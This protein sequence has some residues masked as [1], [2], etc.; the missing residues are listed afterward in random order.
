MKAYRTLFLRVA[1][2][3]MLLCSMPIFSRTATACPDEIS[4]P[5]SF[6]AVSGGSQ[7]QTWTAIDLIGASVLAKAHITAGSDVFS[8]DDSVILFS[9]S[10][11]TAGATATFTVTFAPGVNATGTFTGTLTCD[12][13][14]TYELVGTVAAAGVANALPS[15]VSF[16]ISPNPATDNVTIMSS[17]VLTAEI[18]IYN[19]LGNEIASSKTTTWEWDASSIPTGSYFVRIAG[20]SNSGEQFFIWRRIIIAR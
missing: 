14:R 8:L 17:G 1:A 9:I 18:G 6:T 19:L 16:T 7:S 12:C 3:H 4:G 20:E 5:T 15:N 10:S 11:D 13:G 2:F